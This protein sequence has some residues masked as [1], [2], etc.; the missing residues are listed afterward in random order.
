M[1]P[2]PDVSGWERFVK[3][4]DFEPGVKERGGVMDGESGELTE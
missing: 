1:N 2:G 4:V 3:D